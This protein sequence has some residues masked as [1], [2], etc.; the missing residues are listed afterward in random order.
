MTGGIRFARVEAVQAIGREGVAKL[1]AARVAVVGGGTIGGVL[2]PHL[3]MLGVATL[4]ID[5]GTVNETN[6]GTQMFAEDYVGL[7]KA[8][9][10]ALAMRELNS[11]WKV[12][13]IHADVT[14]MG[15]G[16]FAGVEVVF[17]C[18]DSRA[19]RAAMNEM[20]MRTGTPLVD[21]AID[22]SG[23]SL[24][25][26]V[27]AYAPARGGAC[28]LCPLAPRPVRAGG[29]QPCPVFDWSEEAPPVTVAVSALGA[30]VAAQQFVW[31]LKFLLGRGAEVAG[32][33][34]YFDMEAGMMSVQRL[35]RNPHCALDHRALDLV[36]L[37]R[38]PE[39]LTVGEAFREAERS[40]GAPAALEL[41]RSALATEPRCG[42]CGA[43]ARRFR[44][45]RAI[46]ADETTCAC[47]GKLVPTA[48]G[49]TSRFVEEDAREFAGRSMAELGVPREDVITATARG[50]ETHLLLS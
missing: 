44:L 6:L 21:A 5:K 48:A 45:L 8:Q 34:L 50:R 41:H 4:L 15:L 29:A 2:L 36:R 23:R 13:A 17:T 30:A 25:G 35:E 26:R 38:S 1:R 47:G 24:F 49:L 19:A 31:G 32:K 10:R 42:A 28:Y 22:G 37:G 11:A 12:E 14:R 18:L 40:L 9:L 20:A 46:G 16:I 27:A 7:A 39:E 3:A 33:E 43:S